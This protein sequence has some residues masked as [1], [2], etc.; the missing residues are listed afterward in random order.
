MLCRPE[1]TTSFAPLQHYSYE[2]ILS[3]Y[4]TYVR[5]ERKGQIDLEPEVDEALANYDCGK[6]SDCPLDA[7]DAADNEK[8]L[9]V[10]TS[11]LPEIGD[12]LFALQDFPRCTTLA[13]YRGFSFENQEALDR[14][15]GKGDDVV[16]RYAIRLPSG[17]IIDASTDDRKDLA[18]FSVAR[19]ANDCLPSTQAKLR[20]Q[21]GGKY[22]CRNNAAF[23][24]SLDDRLY[25]VSI[26]PIQK[27][28]EIY[29]SYGSH[30]WG[31]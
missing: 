13:E 15:Y 18:H 11:T 4:D 1:E 30:Y 25:L 7:A 20:E 29:A 24:P 6:A 23:L 27:G 9:E 22:T 10:K 21:S 17:R 5:T 2:S 8:L 19:Y 28:Q 12:G 26:A 31:E 16:A 3:L 14:E